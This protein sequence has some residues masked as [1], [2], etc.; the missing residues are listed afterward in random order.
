MNSDVYK[1]FLKDVVFEIFNKYENDMFAA[2]SDMQK[3][4]NF[5]IYEIIS[6]LIEQS[7]VFG[8]NKEKI[9]LKDIDA[10]RD[11]LK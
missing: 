11:Y 1:N 9:G 6:L 5:A 8:L 2:D 10:E 4:Y 7:E 3:G